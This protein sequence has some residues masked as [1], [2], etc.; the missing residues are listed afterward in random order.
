MLL[1]RSCDEDRVL[2]ATG[3]CLRCRR[4]KLRKPILKKKDKH[5]NGTLAPATYKHD[6]L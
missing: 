3:E 2:D 6:G 4:L 5:F 1:C